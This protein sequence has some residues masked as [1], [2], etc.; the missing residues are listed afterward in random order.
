MSGSSVLPAIVEFKDRRTGLIVFGIL[1]ILVGALSVLMVPMLLEAVVLAPQAG[2]GANLRVFGPA[3]AFYAVLGA[4]LIWLG[5]GSILCRR[6]AHALSLILSWSW[7]L[8][9]VCSMAVFGLLLR[10]FATKGGADSPMFMIMIV[11]GVFE[12][13]FFVALPGAMVLFYRSP[14]V[15]ATCAARDPVPRWTDTCPPPVLAAALWIGAG[16]LFLLTMPLL[17]RS[18]VPW[19]G[20]LLSGAPATLILLICAAFGLYLAWATYR[21]QMAGWWASLGAFAL[22][23]ASAAATLVRV[24]LMEVYRSLGYPEEQIAQIRDLGFF[25]GRIAALWTGLSF[26]AFLLYLLWIRKYFGRRV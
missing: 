15:K 11:M 2:G 24:D 8:A 1:E 20:I 9:G 3:L 25:T 18:V 17:Y 16:A 4:A 5:V 22:L 26:F 12:V 13:I 6:W 7:L 21:L 10:A 19:F 23:S 14:D